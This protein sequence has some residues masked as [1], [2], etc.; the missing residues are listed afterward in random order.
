MVGPK[1]ALI[2]PPPFET[3]DSEALEIIEDLNQNRTRRS[4]VCNRSTRRSRANQ[5]NR[6]TEEDL[7]LN[8][9]RQGHFLDD[10]RRFKR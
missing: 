3:D 9:D 7:E 6:E 10:F 8:K 5:Y 4:T 2:D 1:T